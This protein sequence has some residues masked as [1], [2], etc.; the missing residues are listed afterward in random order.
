MLPITDLNGL[1]IIIKKHITSSKNDS[2]MFP[3]LLLQ[4]VQ[5]ML[6]KTQTKSPLG[7]LGNSSSFLLEHSQTDNACISEIKLKVD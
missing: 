1:N 3:R 7:E 4:I 6:P 2:V 5:K